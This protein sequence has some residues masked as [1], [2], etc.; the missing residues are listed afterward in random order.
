MYAIRSYYEFEYVHYPGA[1]WV[2]IYNW[3]YAEPDSPCKHRITSYN[4]CYTKLLR[5]HPDSVR[6]R[7]SNAMNTIQQIEK[8]AAA[9][10]PLYA[11]EEADLPN[12][13]LWSHPELD[14]VVEA[15]RILSR[16]NFV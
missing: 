13:P 14:Q 11:Q 2:A 4:V 3:R 10:L 5:L 6:I 7:I 16:N 1:G 15:L 8:T 9:L 12:R